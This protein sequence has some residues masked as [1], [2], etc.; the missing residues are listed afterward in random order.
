MWTILK[1]LHWICYNIASILCFVFFFFFF[2]IKSCGI[3]SQPGIEPAACIARWS[4]NHWPAREIPELSLYGTTEYVNYN[5][6]FIGVA[7]LDH[8]CF[9]GRP[10][11]SWIALSCIKLNEK[12]EISKYLVKWKSLSH[13]QIFA[14][15]WTIHSMEFSRPEYWRG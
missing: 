9:L 12:S 5:Y 2:V 15:P 14:N 11:L 3:S 13:V 4:L 8:V 6:S 1:N 10:K 7:L